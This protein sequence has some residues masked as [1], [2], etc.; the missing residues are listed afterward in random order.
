[1]THFTIDPDP[2]Q[3]GQ[4]YKLCLVWDP[5]SPGE[6]I[7][8]EVNYSPAGGSFTTTFT[9]PSIPPYRHC[10]TFTPPANA[11]DVTV[12]A[13]DGFIQDISRIFVK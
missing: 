1:M 4:P 5:P 8:V 6:T 11:E 2:P 7:E 10:R 13:L 3:K 12:H 9:C